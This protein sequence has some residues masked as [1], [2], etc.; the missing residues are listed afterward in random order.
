MEIIRNLVQNLIVIVI[1]AIFLEMLLPAGDLRKYVKMVMGLLII[2]AVVQA[3]GDL[4]RMDYGGDLPSFTQKEDKVQLSGILEAGKKISGDQ[5]QKAIEQ[6]RRGLA[7]Q[8]MA[9]AGINKEVPVVEV[10]VKV[11][12]E[13]SDPGFG[14]LREI[15]LAVAG[16]PDRTPLDPEKGVVAGVEPVSVQVGHRTETVGQEETGSRP[17]REAVAHLVNTVANF[18]NLKPEQ[19]KVVYR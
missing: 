17:P 19:V 2:V 7:N 15:V 5:Q 14:Q 10:E 1:L 3:V 8:V 18:Y 4:V 9:L 11:Q 16:N 6:Y 12:S 13:R